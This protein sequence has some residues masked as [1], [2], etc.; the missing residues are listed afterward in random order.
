ML[1]IS[2][3]S[4]DEEIKEGGFDARPNEKDDDRDGNARD[5]DADDIRHGELAAVHTE[6]ECS[7]S[8]CIGSSA[9]Q[10]NAD[11]ECQPQ[12]SIFID[13][14]LQLALR[15]FQIFCEEFVDP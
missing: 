12:G 4:F 2:I 10:R 11:E 8:S 14:R 7:C 5:T 15:P 3:L 1:I 9:W 6:C 13:L